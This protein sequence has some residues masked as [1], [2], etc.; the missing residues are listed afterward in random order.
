[1]YLRNRWHR[2]ASNPMEGAI[3]SDTQ[4]LTI[5]KLKNSAWFL[6]RLSCENHVHNIIYIYIT[7][8]CIYDDMGVY[9]TLLT[10]H[11]LVSWFVYIYIYLQE[12][13]QNTGSSLDVHIQNGPWPS[14]RFQSL[15]DTFFLG[16][17]SQ[18][19]KK[20]MWPGSRLEALG[21]FRK[22]RRFKVSGSVGFQEVWCVSTVH[23]FK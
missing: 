7:C 15:P 9:F 2:I 5:V 11:I 23:V 19:R 4:D 13:L 1:M 21:S 8:I 16:P 14:Q 6:Q 22:P 3:P 17:K 20:A 10:M 12:P 18:V